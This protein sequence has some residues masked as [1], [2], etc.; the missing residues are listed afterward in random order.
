MPRVQR[1]KSY[2]NVYHIIIRGINRQNIFL[3]K[4]D[5]RKMLKEITN[6]KEKYK[7]EI[8]AL[9][10]MPNHVHFVIN[11][12]NNNI[13]TVM[14]SLSIRYSNYFNKK[15]ERVGHVFENRFKSHVVEDESYLKNVVRYIHKNPENAGITS[16]YPWNSYYEYI[17]KP[18]IIDTE[19]VMQLF[20]NNIEDFKYFHQ[21]YNKNRE[22]GNCYEMVK[23]IDD[24][25]AIKQMKE[26]LKENNLVKVQNY[27]NKKKEEAI[28]KIIKIEGIRKVQIARILGISRSSIDR[29]CK[30]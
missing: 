5:Y 21:N 19:F 7:Y 6:T 1:K 8:Y 4:Q 2:T 16:E 24:E 17:F 10:L 28:K 15:Y 13:S 12:K 9:V 20:S 11:D 22:L 23:T 18:K 25:D 3:D 26:I 14:Q 30:K 27:E 29:I